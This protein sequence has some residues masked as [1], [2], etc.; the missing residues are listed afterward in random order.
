HGHDMLYWVLQGTC[1]VTTRL[2]WGQSI[3]NP[4]SKHDVYYCTSGLPT[5]SQN[6]SSTTLIELGDLRHMRNPNFSF[7]YVH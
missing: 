3:K 2:Y 4:L 6:S 1:L 7:M 5:I